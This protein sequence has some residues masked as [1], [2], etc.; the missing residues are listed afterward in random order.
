MSVGL[1]VDSV[2]NIVLS[3]VVDVEL[4]V[5]FS[6]SSVVVDGAVD[7]IVVLVLVVAVYRKYYLCQ[8]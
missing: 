6:V 5:F 1:L 2:V 3:S 7:E 8:G 4:F